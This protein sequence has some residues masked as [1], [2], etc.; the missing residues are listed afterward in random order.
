MV[1]VYKRDG[2]ER[3]IMENGDAFGNVCQEILCYVA[4]SMIE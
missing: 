1:I 4:V 3:R 2:E